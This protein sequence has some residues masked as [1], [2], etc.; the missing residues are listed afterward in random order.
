MRGSRAG[1][2]L[3]GRRHSGRT[4]E[5]GRRGTVPSELRGSSTLTEQIASVTQQTQKACVAAAV[6]VVSC[7]MLHMFVSRPHYR[8]SVDHLPASGVHAVQPLGLYVHIL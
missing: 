1:H 8:H 4:P 7:A 3:A 2:D 5:A 6:F